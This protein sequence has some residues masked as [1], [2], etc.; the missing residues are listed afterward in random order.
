MSSNSSEHDFNEDV[1]Y[2]DPEVDIKISIK[3]SMK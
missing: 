3:N 1:D 2:S